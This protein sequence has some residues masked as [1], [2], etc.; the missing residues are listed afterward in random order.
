MDIDLLWALGGWLFLVNFDCMASSHLL[1]FLALIFVFLLLVHSS[2]PSNSLQEANKLSTHTSLFVV[3]V[4]ATTD[5]SS[6]SSPSAP[7]VVSSTTKME[8]YLHHTKSQNSRKFST[9]KTSSS[10]SSS[11]TTTR[12]RDFEAAEHEVPSGPNPISN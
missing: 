8:K 6:S 10:S 3:P 1:F 7:P 4:P 12:S 9:S 2:D 5:S 11:S